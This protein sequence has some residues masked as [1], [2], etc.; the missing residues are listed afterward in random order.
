MLYRGRVIGSDGAWL[1]VPRTRP[2]YVGCYI[3]GDYDMVMVWFERRPPWVQRQL[4]R[5]L[6]GWR[7]IDAL[8]G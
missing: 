4:M 7:W 6:L 2:R 5:W 8:E 1:G 3:L